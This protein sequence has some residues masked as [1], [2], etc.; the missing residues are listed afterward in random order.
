MCAAS[1]LL[2]TCHPLSLHLLKSGP[3]SGSM[4]LHQPLRETTAGKQ[5][6]ASHSVPGQEAYPS[7]GRPGEGP[8]GDDH[9]QPGKGQAGPGAQ[10]KGAASGQG[11]PGRRGI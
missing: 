8:A 3:A 7:T 11:T 10:E 2:W 9:T 1:L 6:R 4:W 5:R